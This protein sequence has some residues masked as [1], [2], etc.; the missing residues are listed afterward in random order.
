MDYPNFEIIIVDDGST[1]GSYEEI[2]KM[3]L[4]YPRIK[5]IQT[6]SRR[7]IPRSRNIGIEVAKGDYIAFV[8]LDMKLG[9]G[10]PGELL[11]FL[12]QNHE[13]AGVVPKVLDFHKTNLIQ[14]AG[15]YLIPHTG[16]VIPYG[17]GE[18]DMGQYDSVNEINIGAVGSIVRKDVLV[19]LGGFDETQGMFDDLDL[20]WRIRLI[21]RST[22]CIP[23]AVVYH[24][25][26][27]AWSKRPKSSSK[28]ETEFYIDNSIRVLIKN[29]ELKN[30][31][32]YLPQSM[33][34]MLIR[35]LAGLLRGNTIPLRGS[36]KAILWN[37]ISL[38]ETLEERSKV[39]NMRNVRDDTLFGKTFVRGNFIQIYFKYLKFVLDRSRAWPE[40]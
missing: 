25:T 26:N 11:A 36:L 39:Q 28:L 7:G 6:L 23:S 13:A 16:W 37:I 18:K 4:S 34:I 35:I 40:V 32:R 3:S 2:R 8:E 5:L 38:G 24:W 33:A 17:Y 1:D 9:E 27:K 29:F 20:G 31:I 15:V 10:W 12:Q 14:A 21:G 30:L 19:T 22:F